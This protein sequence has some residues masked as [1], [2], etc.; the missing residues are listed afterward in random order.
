MYVN[1]DVL[2]R[3]FRRPVLGRA[4]FLTISI[5]IGAL[6]GLLGIGFVYVFGVPINIYQVE[7]AV[8]GFATMGAV[9]GL[10]VIIRG[11]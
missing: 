2:L 1:W 5:L 9:M 7:F 10:V 4:L 6:C 11:H 3:Q 8:L